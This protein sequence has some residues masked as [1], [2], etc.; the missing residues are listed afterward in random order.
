MNHAHLAR[1]LLLAAALAPALAG[2]GSTR[3]AEAAPQTVDLYQGFNYRG[4]VNGSVSA[5]EFVS[6]LGDSWSVIWMWEADTKT[7]RWHFPE[8][9]GPGQVPPSI[10]DPGGNG[11]GTIPRGRGVAIYVTENIAGAQIPN[12]AGEGC[13]EP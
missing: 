8:G 6:C 2:A 10:N 7:W 13:L 11:I 5:A 1:G 4:P 9:D 3:I 12:K